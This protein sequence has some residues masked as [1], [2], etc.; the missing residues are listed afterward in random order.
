MKERGIFKRG[1]WYYIRFAGPD[2]KIIYKST[3]S[4]EFKVAEA[5]LVRCKAEVRQ[6]R[7]PELIS[8]E[9]HTFKDLAPQ[10]L[11]WAER[12]KDYRTK[13][14]IVKALV[15]RFGALP[16]HRFS[17]MLLE[18]Y[19]SDRLNSGNA[20]A[21][22]NRAMA[23]LSHMA[24]KACEWRMCG[25]SFKE[26][27]R[28]A[29]RLPENNRRLRYLSG[30]ERQRL[31]EASDAHLKPILIMALNTG[32]RKGEILSLKWEAVDL[33]NRF[34]LLNQMQTKNSERR[35]IPINNALAETLRA[36]PRRLDI[37]WVFFDPLT[38]N[39]YKDVKRSFFSACKRAGVLEFRFHD[40]R[41]DFA[42]RLVMAGV[43]LK[44]V[45]E[46]LG[47]KT[48]AM[49]LRYAHLS[50]T[51]KKAAVGLLDRE[52]NDQAGVQKLK[53]S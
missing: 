33:K 3:H 23:C 15:D 27:V 44:T 41:H 53:Q 38:G 9:R 49:T 14:Y 28:H 22:V 8:T 32:M 2:G 51:H 13:S 12:Q 26:A 45:Q 18:Q 42:S 7:H 1:A 37:P 31:I 48:L 16:L 24:T 39:R 4:K 34:I 21:T 6:G 5:L 10:Y 11:K 29:K 47:H 35:E 30:E 52:N 36:L 43:D 46:L 25:Q 40:A 19:Q 50:P 20:P 17:T